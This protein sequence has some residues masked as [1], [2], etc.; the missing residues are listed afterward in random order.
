MSSVCLECGSHIDDK[1]LNLTVDDDQVKLVCPI[2]YEK[3]QIMGIER[4]LEVEKIQEIVQDLEL[5]YNI[6]EGVK[7]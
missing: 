5:R 7:Q 3:R 2:C 6:E 1:K 4:L